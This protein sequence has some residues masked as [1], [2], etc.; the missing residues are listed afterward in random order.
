MAYGDFSLH[1][2]ASRQLVVVTATD[3]N[4]TTGHLYTFEKQ[5]DQWLPAG[6][7]GKVNLGSN[8]L[9][10]GLGL[11]P[12]QTSPSKQEGD[13][14]APAGVFELGPAFGKYDHVITGLDYQPQNQGH[15]CIDSETN[16]FYNQIVHVDDVEE[17][18]RKDS[19]EPMRR[20]IHA[21]DH[22]YDKG[23][24]IKQNPDNIP[25]KGC[26]VF[27]H[28]WRTAEKPSAGCTTMNE[29][30]LDQLLAWLKKDHKPLLIQLPASE[31][32]K[33]QTDWQ[34]PML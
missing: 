21:G 28:L 33:K 14:K 26:C 1:E 32:Q 18:A 27:I 13:N 24:V 23:I 20:D 2:T 3:W 11:H 19:T 10:W 17:N 6:L 16:P 4:A 29:N 12:D 31:Y 15:Y 5:G 30:Q 7:Q 9:A 34:L 22:L 8:G 25:G